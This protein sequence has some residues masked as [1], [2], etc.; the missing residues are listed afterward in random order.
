MSKGLTVFPFI[1]S[2]L[3]FSTKYS[4]NMIYILLSAWL[5][6]DSWCSKFYNFRCRNFGTFISTGSIH[7]FYCTIWIIS[8]DSYGPYCKKLGPEFEYQ[9]EYISWMSVLNHPSWWTSDIHV[10]YAC[11]LCISDMHFGYTCEICMIIVAW[12]VQN[13]VSRDKN[14]FLSIS[15]DIFI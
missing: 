11:Q 10:S 2:R 6:N 3:R 15:A 1:N 12:C 7:L 5:D 14:G 8:H 9:W 13:G 4:T